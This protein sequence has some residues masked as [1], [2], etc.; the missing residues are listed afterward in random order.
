MLLFKRINIFL[1][2]NVKSFDDIVKI[3]ENIDNFDDFILLWI[4]YFERK[5]NF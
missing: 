4:K 1:R 3:L 2:R 5:G